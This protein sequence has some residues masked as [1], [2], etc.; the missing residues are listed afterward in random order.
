M[1][2]TKNFGR[3]SLLE[4]KEILASMGLS[5]GMTLPEFDPKN[6]EMIKKV[7]SDDYEE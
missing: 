7:M 2:T 6:A 1:L 5:L 4:I 3:K